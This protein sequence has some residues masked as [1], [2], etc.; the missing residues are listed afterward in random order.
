MNLHTGISEVQIIL[1]KEKIKPFTCL[2]SPAQKGT[3]VLSL[4]NSKK[5]FSKTNAATLPVVV[6]STAS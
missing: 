4:T 2:S 6:L 5:L 1:V 3:N